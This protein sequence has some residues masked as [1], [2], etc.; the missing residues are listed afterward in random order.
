MQD[1]HD[2]TLTY[3][4]I[5]RLLLNAIFILKGEGEKKKKVF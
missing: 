5:T 2:S 1:S 4:C 3:L